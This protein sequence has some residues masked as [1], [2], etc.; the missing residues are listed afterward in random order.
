L[1]LARF[2]LSITHYTIILPLWKTIS[3]K[4]HILSDLHI[5]FAPF[6]P[7]E[8]DADV[9]VIA[10]DVHIK[11]HGL[12]WIKAAFPNK[13]VIYVLGN[14]EFYGETIPKLT[15]K[16][17]NLTQGTHIHILENDLLAIDD[18]LFFGSTFWTDFRLY[19]DPRLAGYHATQQMTDFRKIHVSPD[20]HRLRSIDTAA[21]HACS[22]TWLENHINQYSGAIKI[23]ITHHAP[24][25]RSIPETFQEDIVSAAYASNL[26]D[27]VEK[28]GAKIWIHGHI[29]TCRDY[30]IGNT[31]IVCNPRGYPDEYGN[32][33]NPG[34]VVE[35]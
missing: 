15:L 4:I 17:K 33:F 18:V 14:H 32:S 21:L 34:F 30:Q 22:R 6:S 12:D 10:G 9:V 3:V 5:E 23:I 2:Y 8:T 28:S 27:F 19:G 26:D 1:E 35:I 29:H 24:S 13:P 20:Y 7:P 11:S 25:K 31:R 16:L